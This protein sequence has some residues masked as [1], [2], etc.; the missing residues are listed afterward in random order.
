VLWRCWAMVSRVPASYR[1]PVMQSCN[2]AASC[3]CVDS[4][5]FAFRFHQYELI[6]CQRTAE[7][8]DCM[9]YAARCQPSLE[10][11]QRVSS[12]RRRYK[13]SLVLRSATALS[14][15]LQVPLPQESCLWCNDII[16]QDMNFQEFLFVPSSVSLAGSSVVAQSSPNLN[17]A[18]A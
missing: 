14:D 18:T 16:F 7:T 8:D 15:H 9:Q 11:T 13:A 5:L 4:S 3:A 12:S 1:S 10:N 17:I 6:V 2:C